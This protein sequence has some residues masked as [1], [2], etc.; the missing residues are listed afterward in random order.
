MKYWKQKQ[1]T[2]L[3][4]WSSCHR[5]RRRRER[6]RVPSQYNHTMKNR[7]ILVYIQAEPAYHTSV[8]SAI[9]HVKPHTKYS[10]NSHLLQLTSIPFWGLVL[11]THI[12]WTHHIQHKHS[13]R[14]L[15]SLLEA[16]HKSSMPTCQFCTYWLICSSIS[17][18]L[19]NTWDSFSSSISNRTTSAAC[20]QNNLKFIY[21]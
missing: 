21:S 2:L 7:N 11:T 5:I 19:P 18:I 6:G 12:I 20:T 17:C 14:N 16:A 15:M 13:R 3:K 10:Q 4:T 1:N 9:I 8:C